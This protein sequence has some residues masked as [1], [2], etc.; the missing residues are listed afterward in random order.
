MQFIL[1]KAIHMGRSYWLDSFTGKT[2]EEFL[3][4]GA[5]VS[6]FRETRKTTCKRVKAGDYFICYI[7]GV[8]RFIGVL[9]VMSE[10]FIDNKPIWENQL[11]PVRF[12]VKVVHK[13]TP[14]AAVPR[15]LIEHLNY[16]KLTSLSAWGGFLRGSPQKFHPHDGE[17]IIKEIIKAKDN[18]VSRD[19]DK[20]KYFRTPKTYE[21]K[22]GIVTIPETENNEE[23][24]SPELKNIQKPEGNTVTHEQIQWL[25]LEIGSRLGLDVWVARNDKNKEF[26]GKLF[27]DIKGMRT[28][29]PNQFDDATNR[30]IQL[31][32][33][34]WLQGDS[35][36]A[37]FEVEH[38]TSIYS[39]L[40]RMSDL[41]C[42]QPNINIKLFL[43]APDE[44]QDKVFEEIMRPT[45]AKLKKPLPKICK[46]IPY[47]T[48]KETFD[49]HKDMLDV[50]K[51]DFIQKIAISCEGD[52]I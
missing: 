35:I 23:T 46:F 38:T 30:T 48:L 8:Q 45:F 6:G 29:L 44:R 49:K 4:A 26:N 13:L 1:R 52:E 42:M 40:L 9:E 32:D 20:K 19:F 37:A 3:K 10:V 14:E 5:N 47:S 36:E 28:E 50:M 22:N 16:E 25:L 34:L 11:F 31:I 51:P 12:N 33:V 2:W 39:G 27:K 18:P 15:N 17:L 21:T 7:T 43:V 24:H 41:I